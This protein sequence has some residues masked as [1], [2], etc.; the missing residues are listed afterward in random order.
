MESDEHE[1]EEAMHHLD[2][3]AIYVDSG[4]AD[5]RGTSGK[6]I[7]YA[8]LLFEKI[9]TLHNRKTMLLAENM[10]QNLAAVARKIEE[11]STAYIPVFGRE[12]RK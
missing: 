11:W 7:I 2:V 3:L 4:M 12:D 1:Q 9:I 6:L 8:H 5:S 10:V